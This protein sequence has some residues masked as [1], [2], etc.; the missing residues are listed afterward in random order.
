MITDAPSGA[1]LRLRDALIVSLTGLIWALAAGA[2]GL[3]RFS[4]LA[5]AVV[6]L[7]SLAIT[8]AIIDF[9]VRTRRT[10]TAVRP[11]ELA[12][13]WQRT[14]RLM[15]IA[16]GVALVVS[17][18]AFTLIDSAGL[19]TPTICL[20]L[21]LALYPLANALDQREF[22]ATAI[23]LLIIAVVGFVIVVATNNAAGQCVVG[24]AAALALWGTAVLLIRHR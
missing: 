24:L 10:A 7:A 19:I 16:A 12:V 2:V 20:I 3:S 9:G 18:A 22:R 15:A 4:G 8:A 13:D 1:V 5:A 21:G 6:V 17:I 23:A 14:V 11:R